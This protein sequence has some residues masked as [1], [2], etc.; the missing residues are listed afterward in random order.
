MLP[1]FFDP[2]IRKIDDGPG[3]DG[4]G[5]VNIHL[6]NFEKGLSDYFTLKN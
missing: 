1:D 6:S 2:F 4:F 5:L 3:V